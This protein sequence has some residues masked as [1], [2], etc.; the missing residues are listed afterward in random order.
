MTEKMPGQDAAR[1]DSRPGLLLGTKLQAPPLRPSTVP[2][3][4]LSE[5][6]QDGLGGRLI[7]VSAP[8]GFGKT[9]ALRQWLAACPVPAGW[10][11]IDEGD[12]D[13]IRF[14]SYVIAALQTVAPGVGKT[15]EALLHWP[16]TPPVES[17]LTLLINDITAYPGKLILALDDYHLITEPA[18]HRA[19]SFLIDNLPPNLHVAI[20]TRIDPPLPLARLRSRGELVEIRAED[21]RF[22][23]GE[24]VTFFGSWASL[25]LAP[26]DIAALQARTEG[27][28]AALNMAALC[29]A[30]PSAPGQTDA[31]QFI[32]SFTGS[33]RHVLDFLVAEVFG[34]QAAHV[35]DFLLQTSVLT[36]LCGPLCDA[37][38]ETETGVS[39]T[40]ALGGQA[41][42][43]WL[44]TANLFLVPLDGERRW[45]RYHHLFGELLQ[46]RL[47]QARP[48]LAPVLHARAA[49][50]Y[51]GNGDIDQAVEHSLAAQDW[52]RAT[53]LM[54]E[55]LRAYLGRGRM[56]TILG[57]IKA[58]PEE[59]AADSP[60]LCIELGW[61]LLFAT[62]IPALERLL[63][64]VE[65]ALA[66][67]DRNGVEA[68]SRLPASG[69]WATDRLRAALGAMQAYLALTKGNAR[70]ALELARSAAAYAPADSLWERVGTYWVLG[71]ASRAVGDLTGA[72]D[73]FA[74][75]VRV[76]CN[77][78]DIF[79]Q[80]T[81]FNHLAYTN[82]L[83]GKL[84][85]AVEYYREAL[86]RGAESGMEGLPYLSQMQA[87]L[88]GAL[89]EQNELDEALTL[90]QEAAEK[91]QQW[92]SGNYVAW[93]N[94]FLA[95]VLQ[96]RGD[97]QG[98]AEAVSIADA[99][100]R[101]ALVLP[102]VSAQV[103][104][105]QVRLWLA[106]GNLP[107]AD[108]WA[109][110]LGWTGEDG[111]FDEARELRLIALARVLVVGG[112]QKRAATGA[113]DERLAESLRLL[114]YLEA[115]A[116]TSGRVGALI[117]TLSLQAV[118][119]Y[120]AAGQHVTPAAL[121]AMTQSLA[122][123][124]PGGYVRVFIDLGEPAVELLRALVAGGPHATVGYAAHL[125]QAFPPGQ[126]TRNGGGR[127]DQPM[128]EPLT[129]REREV[130]RLL[131][132]GFSNRAMAEKLIVT[133]G[134][135]KTHV[136]NLLAKLGA[137]SRT[138]ALARARE[139]DLL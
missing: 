10:F 90:A 112:S 4:R 84:N 16:E 81:S 75:S 66:N 65:I 56:D 129:E 25:G 2:R 69:T 44:E 101:S 102:T 73:A 99:A 54:E 39:D 89:L 12:N 119:L 35:Q 83:R 64:R 78:D 5:L 98:A 127:Q 125:L 9:T 124:Q 26:K 47:R 19:T 45:Y 104:G 86:R 68:G 38:T 94:L 46:A 128:V 85:Q 1:S 15:A 41:M 115:S 118:A 50:W 114:R 40:G 48:E 136:H 6:F 74:E 111:P 3:P 33:H 61:A 117:E 30:R 57:W 137:A 23:P 96:A 51:E 108:K 72:A 138:Q 63:G 52:R 121:A 76:A 135:V 130:L 55:H 49:A 103:D 43:E 105:A 21:L 107:D 59:V 100:R 80:V 28:I 32:Q 126:T 113:R 20:A 71:Y 14:L 24:A 62:R 29:L 95:Q 58:L 13:P 97:L 37:V 132:A 123:A 34:R 70:Q 116:L 67:R 133:E 122:L 106:Q 93:A 18:L 77:G 131:A 82:R 92:H 91:A 134:T 42:L 7:L 53:R 36:Q 87:G 110:Q 11:S 109:A 8:A 17:I 31:A 88:A 27:W 22:T 120:L 79:M 139:L 60:R